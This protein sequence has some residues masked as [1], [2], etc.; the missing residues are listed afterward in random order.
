MKVLALALQYIFNAT[1]AYPVL[2]PSVKTPQSTNIDIHL[3]LGQGL[4]VIFNIR[5]ITWVFPHWKTSSPRVHSVVTNRKLRDC[6]A[7]AQSQALWSMEELYSSPWLRD[8][9]LVL[10]TLVVC[11]FLVVSSPRVTQST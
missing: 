2:L 8:L 10:A 7:A 5:K 6:S 9:C 3:Y 4:W 1:H 11:V